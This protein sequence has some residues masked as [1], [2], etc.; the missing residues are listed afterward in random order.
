ME[1]GD[2]RHLLRRLTF[3]S[4]GRDERAFRDR[5]P[6]AVVAALFAGARTAAPPA[7]PPFVRGTWTNSALRLAGM[8]AAQ[9]DV[10]RAGQLTSARRD[11][12]LLR[13]WWLGEMI[14]GPSPLR[15]NLV[16]F[17]QGVFGSSTSAV[18]IPHAVYGCNALVRQTCLGTIPALLERLVLDPA[19]I[20]QIGMDGHG[21]ERVSDR[22]AKLILDHWTVGPGEYSDADVEHLSRALTGWTLAAPGGKGP[23]PVLDPQAAADARRTGLVPRFDPRQFDGGPKTILGSTRAFDAR[24]A[25]ALLARHP[26]TAR[27]FS[28][29]LIRYLGIEDGGGRLENALVDDYASSDGSI[30]ALVDRAVTSPEFLS[31]ASRWALVKSPVQLA[32]GACRQLE[33]A[34]PPLAEISRWLAAAGQTLFDT[35]NSGEGGWPGDTAWITPPDRLVIRYQLPI[36]LGGQVPALG[37][38]PER[39]SQPPPIAVRVARSVQTASARALI[40]RLDPAP[41]LDRSAIERAVSR[42]AERHLDVIRRVMM[43]PEYQLA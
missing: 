12:E 20:I 29:H 1:V 10:L 24:S 28:R 30:E 33:I 23:P 21:R 37:I 32:V 36:V 15:E 5:T 34:A 19:M 39:R 25:M 42:G 26:A 16:L 43:T 8:T 4:T 35:P 2:L 27:R 31:T 18:D 6:G 22:P 9:Y 7:T 38:G 41:G 14:G 40:E 3:A 11:I 17:F 13:Q